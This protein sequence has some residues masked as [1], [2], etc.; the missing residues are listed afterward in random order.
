MRIEEEIVKQKG[1][2]TWRLG[3]F[4]IYLYSKNEKACL[5]ENAKGVAAQTIR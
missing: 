3:K 4:S 2:R 5:E 1:S